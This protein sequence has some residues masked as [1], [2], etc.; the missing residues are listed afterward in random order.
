MNTTDQSTEHFR[1]KLWD[2]LQRLDTL[3]GTGNTE[4]H[5][6]TERLTIQIAFNRLEHNEYNQCIR[7]NGII[8]DARLF[9]NPTALT[10]D[11]CDLVKTA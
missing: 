9:E 2:R 10:C 7:C 5:T 8:S 4:F 3:S 6:A 1:R 11:G